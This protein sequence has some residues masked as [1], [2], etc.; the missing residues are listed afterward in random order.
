MV[1][2]RRQG[3]VVGGRPVRGG[4][5]TCGLVHGDHG[6]VLHGNDGDIVT[7]GLYRVEWAPVHH[8]AN[9][10]IGAQGRVSLAIEQGRH[11]RVGRVLADA[12]VHVRG[13]AGSRV[14]IDLDV[15]RA[16]G[17]GAAGAGMVMVVV[18]QVIGE[19]LIAGNAER[20]AGGARR[21]VPEIHCTAG[22]IGVRADDFQ[23]VGCD[24]CPVLGAAVPSPHGWHGRNVMLAHGAPDGHHHD[25]HGGRVHVALGVGNLVVKAVPTG[26]T[27]IGCV[28]HRA[29]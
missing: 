22:P 3:G 7:K 4:G 1:G 9:V 24:F 29:G 15:N 20:Y 6:V 11:A 25:I 19:M 13:A 26:V 2:A 10:K 5:G 28:H 14:D 23:G 12:H 21:V 18:P 17:G 16:A 27:R 8:P